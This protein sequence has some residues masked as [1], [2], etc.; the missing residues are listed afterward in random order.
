MTNTRITDPEILERRFPV[1]LTSFTLRRGS[2]GSGRWPGGDGCVR[3]LEA[4]RRLTF[5][6]LSERRA[7]AP[8][9]LAGGGD[10]QR[11]LNL[12]LRANGTAVNL[13][14]KAT[15][16]LGAGDRLRVLTPGGGGFGAPGEGEEA[17]EEEAAA[18]E[19][20]P[21]LPEPARGSVADYTTAQEG[22]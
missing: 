21:R 5:S 17:A 12:W 7:L 16:L 15:V 4:L 1:T 19:V 8:P 22:A 14:G 9:G 6:V 13:G 3:E 20:A 2:G 11:G 10:A 18:A